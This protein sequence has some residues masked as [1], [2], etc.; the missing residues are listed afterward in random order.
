MYDET[1]QIIWQM[2]DFAEV[3]LGSEV[4]LEVSFAGFKLKEPA[5]QNGRYVGNNFGR[6]HRDYTEEESLDENKKPKVFSMWVRNHISVCT[7]DA[8]HG[9]VFPLNYLTS[10]L[11]L[12]RYPST[13]F[14]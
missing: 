6:P 11:M 1:W 5:N 4:D 12:P 2:W 10:R 9:P 3:L 8:E 13:T 7:A 14:V